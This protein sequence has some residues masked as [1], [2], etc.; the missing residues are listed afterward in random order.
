M[1]PN[2]FLRCNDPSFVVFFFSVGAGSE[3]LSI[4]LRGRGHIYLQQE[5]IVLLCPG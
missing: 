5:S 4:S 1:S 2:L 3:N